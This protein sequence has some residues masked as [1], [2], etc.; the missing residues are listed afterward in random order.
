MDELQNSIE[1]DAS[2]DQI[3]TNNEAVIE[4]EI[5]DFEIWTP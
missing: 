1:H 4:F 3:D 2:Q 5:G